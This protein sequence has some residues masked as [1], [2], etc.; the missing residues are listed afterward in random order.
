MNFLKLLSVTILSWMAVLGDVNAY[1][2]RFEYPLYKYESYVD[3]DLNPLEIRN[4]KLQDYEYR[5]RINDAIKKYR[6]DSLISVK[7]GLKYQIRTRIASFE[8]LKIT[9]NNFFDLSRT[10][11]AGLSK[12]KEFPLSLSRDNQYQSLLLYYRNEHPG[13]SCQPQ[14]I[15][16]VDRQQKTDDRIHTLASESGEY[17]ETLQLNISPADVKERTLSYFSKKYFGSQ[18]KPH[19][20]RVEK[21]NLTVF[22]QI[23]NIP[24][25][26]KSKIF[27]SAAD[28][29]QQVNIIASIQGFGDYLLEYRDI[30]KEIRDGR[31]VLSLDLHQKLIDIDKSL[32]RF[33]YINI[34]A[35]NLNKDD[36]AIQHMPSARVVIKEIIVN[37]IKS[38]IPQDDIYI[39]LA[40]AANPEDVSEKPLMATVPASYYSNQNEYSV[41][42]IS[43][44]PMKEL[45]GGSKGSAYFEGFTNQVTGLKC[46][47]IPLLARLVR[48]EAYKFPLSAADAFNDDFMRMFDVVANDDT[49][50]LQANRSIRNTRYVTIPKQTDSAFR[51]TQNENIKSIDL[52]NGEMFIHGQK[53]TAENSGGFDR[54]DVN[55]DIEKVEIRFNSLISTKTKSWLLVR[56]SGLCNN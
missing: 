8:D 10:D 12:T 27:I 15:F 19:W 45:L 20:S 3:A 34:P 48:Y 55:G 53:I 52:I 35:N 46:R 49:S 51:S 38:D 36:L 29:I 40:A 30:K 32:S 16:N 21:E 25:L 56:S 42:E 33:G 37:V 24:L 13:N 14:M 31:Q 41:L 44:S 23:V 54:I 11:V 4:Q 22:Q 18:E 6:F 47:F 17:T 43:L 28:Q 26:D 39:S 2:D 50:D 7:L 1:S 5:E 9:N